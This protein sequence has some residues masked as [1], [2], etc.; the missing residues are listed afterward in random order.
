MSKLIN[1]V[2]LPENWQDNFKAATFRTS[3]NL[4]LSQAMIEMLCAVADGVWWDRSQF[5]GNVYKPDN[6]VASAASLLKRG[7]VKPATEAEK[8][9]N[10][11]RIMANDEQ[12]Y[13]WNN[14]TLT[15][16]GE[17]VV[18]IFKL[19]GIFVEADAAIRKKS[20]RA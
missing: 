16:I 4:S 13:E 18:N 9:A 6:W 20:R 10:V 15:P 5:C 17:S 7:L 12:S 8:K 3:F 19:A 2:K 11:A 14:W 1:S